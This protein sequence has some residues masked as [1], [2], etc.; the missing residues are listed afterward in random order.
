[1]DFLIQASDRCNCYIEFKSVT[2]LHQ[3]KGYF[4]DAVTVRGQKHLR[5]L[6]AVAASGH[7][8]VLLFAGSALGD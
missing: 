5:E 8:A 3:G 7:W 1:M 6:S 2:P 4:P